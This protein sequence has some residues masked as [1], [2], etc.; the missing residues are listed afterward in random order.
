MSIDQSI[1]DRLYREQKGTCQFCHRPIP[2]FHVH[3]AVIPKGQTNYRKFRTFL[4]M[5]E[6]LVLVCPVCDQQHGMMTGEKKKNIIWSIKIDL[7]WPMQEWLDSIPMREHKI[8][9]YIEKEARN[10]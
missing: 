4:D 3:H 7:G 9:N 2:P 1:I 6:N 8:F 10:A 5:G